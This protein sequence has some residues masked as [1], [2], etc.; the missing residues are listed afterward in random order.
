MGT[1]PNWVAGRES[2]GS[3]QGLA[4][5]AGELVK[6]KIERGDRYS[7]PEIY[8]LELTVLEILRGDKAHERMQQMGLAYSASAGFVPYLVR[9]RF[10]YFSRG[11]G[12]E[13]Q[14]Q[15]FIIGN[16]FFATVS[17]GANTEYPMPQLAQQPQPPLVD[18]PFS[19]GEIKEGW[20]L[21]EAPETEPQP[22]LI[23][24]REFKEFTYGVWGPVWF[25]LTQ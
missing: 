2:A 4:A 7:A 20:I 15:P 18:V 5:A 25:R 8:N 19:P 16:D 9:L 3:R 1:R 13:R 23:F 22:F 6:T 12:L 21:V 11:R 14:N 17:S 24:K 10:G